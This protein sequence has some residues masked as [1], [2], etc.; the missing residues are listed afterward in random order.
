MSDMKVQAV[1]LIWFYKHWEQQEMWSISGWN[2]QPQ[3]Q[4]SRCEGSLDNLQTG[5]SAGGE[6]IEGWDR[7]GGFWGKGK[8]GK[9]WVTSL[10]PK[11]CRRTVT[12]AS[13]MFWSVKNKKDGRTGPT[14]EVISKKAKLVINARGAWVD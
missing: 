4:L 6:E 12:R 13:I 1:S 2:Q 11:Q 8:A 14:K 7:E 5:H 10:Y 3:K 9:W